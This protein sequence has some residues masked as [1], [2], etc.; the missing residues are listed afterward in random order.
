MEPYSTLEVRNDQSGHPYV[1]FEPEK[2]L[3]EVAPSDQPEAIWKDNGGLANGSENCTEQR[4]I[5]GMRPRSFCVLAALVLLIVAGAVAGGTAGGILSRQS[6]QDERKESP[7]DNASLTPSETPGT[8][9]ILANSSLAASSLVN[10]EGYTVRSVFFQDSSGALVLRQWDSQT[11]TW[12]TRN[13]T[14]LLAM[15]TSRPNIRAYPGSSLTAASLEFE[16]KKLYETW[17]WFLTPDNGIQMVGSRDSTFTTN[18]IGIDNLPITV[19]AAAESKLAATWQGC[20]SDCMG[21]WI[22]AFQ[23]RQG[24]I[25]VA[26]ASDTWRLG[27]TL[28]G[29]IA[30]GSSMAMVPQRD[31]SGLLKLSLVAET[32]SSDTG[33]NIQSYS[34]SEGANWKTDGDIL[35]DISYTPSTPQLAGT[36][37]FNYTQPYFLVLL[38]NGT[39]AGCLL[40]GTEVTNIYQPIKFPSGPSTNFTSIATTLDASFYGISNGEILEYHIDPSNP[41][42]LSYVGVVFP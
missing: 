25:G 3:P 6:T 10:A 33:G 40:N 39:V 29:T 35:N 42:V 7:S 15:D 27:A 32:V 9:P 34:V 13:L 8:G 21:N 41:S 18:G 31:G 20:S 16:G 12:E 28:D 24:H 36:S 23:N 19:Y 14:S 5:W 11:T 37:L 1:I 2:D 26:N 4:L 38:S 17:V 30:A 22:I